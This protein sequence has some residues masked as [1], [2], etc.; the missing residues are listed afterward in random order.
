MM[1]RLLFMLAFLVS[2][3]FAAVGQSDQENTTPEQTT[4]GSQESESETIIVDGVATISLDGSQS[5]ADVLGEGITKVTKL[6]VSGTLTEDDFGTMKDKMNMLQVLDMSG[7]TTF[8]KYSYWNNGEN[9]QQ[10][11]IP[12]DALLGKLTLQEVIFPTCLELINS[13]A[14]SGCN[15]LSSIVFKQTEQEQSQLKLF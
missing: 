10:N 5:L 11:Q 4:E 1:K 9:I 12:S 6:I 2:F 15:N 13:S 14:F 3:G 7:V 8:P